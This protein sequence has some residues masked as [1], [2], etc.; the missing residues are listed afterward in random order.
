MEKTMNTGLLSPPE[1]GPERA[2]RNSEESEGPAS[3]GRPHQ[4]GT[5]IAAPDSSSCWRVSSSRKLRL[6]PMNWK[7]STKSFTWPRSDRP[8]V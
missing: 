2:Q 4:P 3:G 8:R 6:F 7:A 5:P 1:A